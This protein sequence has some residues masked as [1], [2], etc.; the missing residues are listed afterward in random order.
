MALREDFGIKILTANVLGTS[1]KEGY[2]KDDLMGANEAIR[3]LAENPNPEN[4][5]QI[6]QIMAYSVQDI[7][8]SKRS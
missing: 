1:E 5:Y 2:T 3:R 7:F 8:R 6:G 4:R